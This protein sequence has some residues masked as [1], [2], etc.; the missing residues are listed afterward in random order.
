MSRMTW[1]KAWALLLSAGNLTIAAAGS[2]LQA[3]PVRLPTTAPRLSALLIDSQISMAPTPSFPGQGRVLRTF[4]DEVIMHLEAKHTGG[5]LSLWTNIT[6]P[7]G[8]PPLHYHL[9]ED[10]QGRIS[11]YA[12]GQWREVPAGSVVYAPRNSVHAF[13]NIGDQ[14]SRMIV[15]ISPAGFENFFARCAE[16]IAKPGAPDMRRIVEFSAEHGIHFVQA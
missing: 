16:E 10:E 13:K 4:G 2:D 12:V 5:A 6:P 1:M 15:S 14:P 9:N 7:G 11:F 8:G 3:P